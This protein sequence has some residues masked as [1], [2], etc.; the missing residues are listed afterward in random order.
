MR[1]T[2][3][4]PDDLFRRTKVLAALQ[5]SSMKDLIVRAIEREV[6]GGRT[7]KRQAPVKL[8]LIKSK[9]GRKLDLSDFDFDDLILGYH[10][11]HPL[12]SSRRFGR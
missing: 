3:D 8:P 5:G 4:L 2:G 1:T 11:P 10:A 12:P 6:S 7:A 9:T